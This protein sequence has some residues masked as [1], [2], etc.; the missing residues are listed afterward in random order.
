MKISYKHAFLVSDLL[1]STS[2]K[3][4]LAIFM[5]LGR[6]HP[7]SID[8]FSH[9]VMILTAE[10]LFQAYRRCSRLIV[11]W[12]C[13]PY[14]VSGKINACSEKQTFNTLDYNPLGPAVLQNFTP[15]SILTL[16]YLKHELLK[17]EF[18]FHFVC[19][20]DESRD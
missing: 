1:C 15:C 9:Y 4:L 19:F 12:F 5:K 20:V 16:V 13:G 14:E 3:V 6:H 11:D 10:T 2:N 17:K 7:S 18:G 8:L